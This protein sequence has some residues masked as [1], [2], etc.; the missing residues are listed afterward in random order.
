M[1]PVRE[2]AVQADRH[3]DRLH[4][5]AARSAAFVARDAQHIELADQV[6]GGDR[7]VTGHGWPTVGLSAF[8]V[9]Q[10]LGPVEGEV[11]RSQSDPNSDPDPIE[12][13]QRSS[14]LP[15]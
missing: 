15:Q 13:P 5:I 4:V 11:A 2:L 3:G 7:T 1:E 9:N 8:R 6:A 10:P 12:I 14:L